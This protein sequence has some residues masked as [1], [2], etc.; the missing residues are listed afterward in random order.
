LI[1][2][3][4]DTA[5]TGHTLR[6]L[7]LPSVSL[8]WVEELIKVR[9]VI[10]DRRRMIERVKGKM[11]DS[12]P[13]EEEEDE[14]MKELKRIKEECL[15]IEEKLKSEDVTY[16]PILNAE[17]VPLIETERLVSFLRRFG[18]HIER[19][20]VNKY[21]PERI[22]KQAEVIKEIFKKFK[23]YEIKVIPY[24]DVSPRG[25]KALREVCLTC[26]I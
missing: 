4:F 9:R 22:P 23:D 19:I 12:P 18:M 21:M 13:S 15:A 2:F 16:I 17:E 11:P 24:M 7:S 3:C 25:L 8:I 20:I 10:L 6:V 5:P 26:L 14:V 1:L